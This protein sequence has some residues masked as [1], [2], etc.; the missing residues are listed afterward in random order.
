MWSG[1]EAGGVDGVGG[2]A[3][4]LTRSGGSGAREL[5][6]RPRTAAALGEAFELVLDR[7]SRGDARR[8]GALDERA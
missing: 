1:G 4:L 3:R 6:L 5:V 2:A 8:G 7:R